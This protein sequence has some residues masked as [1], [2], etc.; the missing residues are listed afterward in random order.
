M[1][2]LLFIRITA[3]S[4]GLMDIKWWNTSVAPQFTMPLLRAVNT[5]SL[6][7]LVW[8]RK[9]EFYYRIMATMSHSEVLKSKN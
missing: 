6:K 9:E 1:A 2:G 5:L 3:L 4:I 7:T 8:L